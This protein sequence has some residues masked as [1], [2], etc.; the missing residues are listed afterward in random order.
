MPSFVPA[1]RATEY[2]FYVSLVSQADT[3]LFQNNPTIAAG[4][5]LVSTDGSSTTNLDT[6]P[7]VTPASSDSVKITVSV[8]EMTGD[9]VKIV[10]SDAAGAQWC[11]QSWNIQTARLQMNDLDP[12][13]I[14]TAASAPTATTLPFASGK[15]AE[16]GAVVRIL[17]ATAGAGQSRFVESFA[18]GIATVDTWTTTP[19][20]T[21]VYAHFPVP[22]GSSTGVKVG[23]VATDALDSVAFAAS[24]VTKF[25][26]EVLVELAQAI[27]VAAPS[28]RAGLTLLYMALR[29]KV[30]VD[31]SF[32]EIHNDAGTVVSKKAITDDGTTYSEAKMVAGP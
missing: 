31:G 19:T 12:A 18:A 9:N 2:I 28:A 26:D 4:D 5:F 22:P 27:P 20:G 3:K 10:A 11:D 23:S 21:V 1:K 17:S 14:N 16:V 7:V 8:A 29:D 6:L 30:D 25:W 15:T 32:K 24:A 13:D